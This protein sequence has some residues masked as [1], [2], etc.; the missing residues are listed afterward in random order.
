M[1]GEKI[2][3]ICAAALLICGLGGCDGRLDLRTDF[4]FEVELLPVPASVLPGE[5]V[6]M[7]FTLKSVG[8][9]YDSTRYYLRYFQYA[10]KGTLS[11]EE[12]LA[13]VPN[14]AYELPKKVFRLYF[15]PQSGTQHRLGLTFYDSFDHRHEV[16]LSFAVEKEEEEGD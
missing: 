1:R 4:G 10:G 5:E 13:L 15:A 14:D 12:G 7:R 6:E 2:R 11:S 8:G 9:S 16:E 3:Q